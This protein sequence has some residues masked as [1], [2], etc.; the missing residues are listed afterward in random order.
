MPHSR[1]AFQQLLEPL[2]RRMLKTLVD[3]H[4]GD[5][6]VGSGANAWTC[7]RHLK[8]LLFGQ[9]AG[10]NSLRDFEQAFSAK[11]AALYHLDLRP[12][13][14]STL[15]DASAKRPHAFFRDVCQSLMG[16]MARKPR[17]Q[18]KALI[19]LLDASPI[20][21]RDHRFAWAE[22]DARVRGLKLHLLYDPLDDH[23]VHFAVT[24]HK[25]SDITVARTLAFEEEGT[26]VFDKGYTDYAWWQEIHEAGA[27]FITRLKANAHRRDIKPQTVKGDAILAD[28]TLK[29]GHKKP[30]GGATNP[31][32][33]TKLREIVVEREDKEPLHLVTNDHT[34]TAKQ[35]AALYKQRWEIELFFKWIKQN[36]K[37]KSFMG[38]SQNAVRIQIYVAL[39]A[40]MLLRIFKQTYARSHKVGTRGLLIRLKVCL[41]DKFDLTENSKPPPTPPQKKPPNPQL[42]LP[43]LQTSAIA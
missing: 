1:T 41:H 11:P 33:D 9:L 16:A 26:Y 19:Q 5:H 20:P 8:A 6:G 2:D 4:N 18:G 42:S 17:A 12:P 24:S 21:L 40:F 27:L 34:R 13:R 39:I 3:K 36:L 28:Q 15:S 38:H 23:P 7:I 29:V 31:L 30:R 25:I 35:I 32:Y 10:L 37:I 14:R 22:A 43:I